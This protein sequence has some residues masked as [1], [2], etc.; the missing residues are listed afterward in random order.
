MRNDIEY[1]ILYVGS[2]L[3]TSTE[4]THGAVGFP[5]HRA[6]AASVIS[7]QI[8]MLATQIRILDPI[9]TTQLKVCS[10][11]TWHFFLELRVPDR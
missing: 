3:L 10:G 1:G 9:R 8:M 5:G 2:K 11:K 6:W 4:G 7:P